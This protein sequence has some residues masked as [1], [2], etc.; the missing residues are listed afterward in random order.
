MD[1][2]YDKDNAGAIVEEHIS[3]RTSIDIKKALR[4]GLTSKTFII[5]FSRN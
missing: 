3:V 1:V 4:R 5:I 2:G